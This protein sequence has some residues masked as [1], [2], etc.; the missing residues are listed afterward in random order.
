MAI[1]N[2]K[3]CVF[4]DV[5]ADSNS[6][7]WNSS[8]NVDND[9]CYN[10]WNISDMRNTDL[11][12]KLLALSSDLQSI[13]TNTTIQ[14]ATNGNN[15]ALVS[16]SDKLF[17]AAGKEMGETG[18]SRTEENSALITWSY[19]TTHTQASNRIKYD[20]TNTARFYWLR[21]PGSGSNSSVVSVGTNGVF[22]YLGA[23]SKY[24]FS[25]CFAF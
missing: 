5:G 15:G 3:H 20:A 18:Y 22:R 7:V 6:V 25:P 16:T 13:I 17:I 12:A 11:P 21:S 10:N 24:W 9:N 14:T 19:R 4:E 23:N 2:G 8:T 1:Y